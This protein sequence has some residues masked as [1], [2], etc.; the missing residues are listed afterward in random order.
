MDPKVLRLKIL[1]SV[2]LS[3]TV[4]GRPT[5]LLQSV[6]GLRAAAMT[7]WWSSSGA[8]RARCPKNLNRKDFA[9]SETGKQPVILRT[10]SFVVRLVCGI[11]NISACTRYQ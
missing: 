8:E 7:R 4:L 1:I 5:G 6:G 9:I 10:V 11:R 2:V 3:Q